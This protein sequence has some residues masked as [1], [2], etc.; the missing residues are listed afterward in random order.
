MGRKAWQCATNRAR[1]IKRCQNRQAGTIESN[2]T[3][4]GCQYN[5]P[6]VIRIL[7]EHG[8]RITAK[9][10]DSK[11]PLDLAAS[12]GALEAARVL[13]ELGAG[14]GDGMVS[15]ARSAAIRGNVA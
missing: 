8:A 2:R 4:L 10:E 15:P 5:H 13:L 3:T 1:N 12:K 6:T 11:T 7:L 14:I 9:D